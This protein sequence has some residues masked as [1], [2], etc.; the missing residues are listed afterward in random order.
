MEQTSQNFV[1]SY[2]TP[3]NVDFKSKGVTSEYLKMVS[4]KP[5]TIKNIL[6]DFSSAEFIHDNLG[7]FFK[8]TA[9]QLDETT[10][11]VRDVLMSDLFIG[12][13]TSEIGKR[14]GLPN[15]KAL[16]IRNRIIAELFAPAIED[17]KKVQ[18]EKFSRQGEAIPAA[19][20]Q[21]PAP[22]VKTNVNPNNVVNLRDK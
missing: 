8:L 21:Q 18:R 4:E 13:M 6:I 15:D 5:E 12:N 16:E 14:L 7:P 2:T 20:A 3:F 22:Q 10:R 17:I 1:S 9:E 11:I 19:P